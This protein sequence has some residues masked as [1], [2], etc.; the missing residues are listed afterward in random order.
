M[1]Y[2]PVKD[3]YP[4]TLAPLHLQGFPPPPSI[5]VQGRPVQSWFL[6]LCA[7]LH[8]MASSPFHHSVLVRSWIFKCLG[9]IYDASVTAGHARSLSSPGKLRRASSEREKIICLPSC[10]LYSTA[11]LSQRRVKAF[12]KPRDPAITILY[13]CS[14]VLPSKVK[15]YFLRWLKM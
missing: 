15:P 14:W 10:D 4:V 1:L 5:P 12:H 13:V 8:P 2:A 11:L 6:V 3:W 9:K 7:I